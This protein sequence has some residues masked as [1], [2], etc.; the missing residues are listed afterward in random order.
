MSD[1]FLILRSDPSNSEE[2]TNIRRHIESLC[3]AFDPFVSAGSEQR[4]DTMVEHC[5]VEKR[6]EGAARVVVVDDVELQ[7]R[8]CY[9]RSSDPEHEHTVWNYLKYILE[10]KVVAPEELKD[11]ARQPDVDPGALPRL[12]LS[13]DV[14]AFD[15]ETFRLITQ[16]LTNQDSEIR[17]GAATAAMALK[18]KKLQP[19]LKDAAARETT[20]EGRRAIEYV[21]GVLETRGVDV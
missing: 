20:D 14:N 17:M 6:S 19:A 1:P 15:E 2:L 12:A 18:W 10:S 8:Y 11:D 13:L 9:V 3:M 7:A 16:G 4:G 21:V 5:W